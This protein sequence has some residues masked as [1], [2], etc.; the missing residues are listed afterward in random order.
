MYLFYVYTLKIYNT[1]DIS[2]GASNEEIKNFLI[3]LIFII[4][5]A[6]GCK[7]SEVE[8]LK[9]QV[10]GLSEKI[11]VE[12]QEDLGEEVEESKESGEPVS[13]IWS[14]ARNHIGETVVMEG[15]VVGT[16]YDETAF[17]GTID[18]DTFLDIGKMHPETG[19]GLCMD[20]KP[21]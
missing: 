2:G 1:L 5:F 3:V 18:D 9:D 6:I 20:P 14:E 15:P 19:G 12:A 13:I 7:N 11:A 21:K 17:E 8:E 4:S 10:A 16:Y